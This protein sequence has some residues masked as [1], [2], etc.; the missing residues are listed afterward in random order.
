MSLYW[1]NSRNLVFMEK[2]T[3]LIPT[4]NRIDGLKEI[5]NCLEEYT[6]DKKNLEVIIGLDND[7]FLTEKFI[8]EYSK[9]FN[10]IIKPVSS[11]RGK[12]YLDQANRLKNMVQNSNGN[13]FVHLADD[14]KIITNNWDILLKDKVK[15]LPLDEIYLLYPKHNQERNQKWPLCQI[16]SRKWF[17]TINK[18]VN[19]FETDT[20]LMI[21]SSLLNRNYFFKEIEIFHKT[22]IKD[23]VHLEGRA[24]TLKGKIIKGSILSI[25]GLFLALQDYYILRGKITNNHITLNKSLINLKIIFKFPYFMFKIKKFTGINYFKL[26]LI[27]IYQNI[28]R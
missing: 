2:I 7:D 5:L 3:V 14:M 15:T 9:N 28:F 6:C 13:Y 20:E 24:N 11:V 1:I 27:D 23:Q 18:Y 26:F 4:R 17:N 8:K 19:S 16:T 25:A 12:G 22:N 21:I 10:F